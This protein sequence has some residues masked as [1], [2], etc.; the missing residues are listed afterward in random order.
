MRPNEI[1]ELIGFAAVADHKS[2]RRAA[3]KLNLTPS[4]LSHSLRSL[5]ERLGVRLLNRTTRSVGLTDAG[6]ALLEQVRPALRQLDA[7]VEG[8]NA[9]S[10]APRGTVR[11]NVPHL[12][13][14]MVFGR[15]LGDFARA[16]PGIVLDIATDDRFVDIVAQ[17][18]DAGIRLGE[19]VDQDMVAVRVTA[20]LRNI[21]VG[22]PGYF[23]AHP[24]PLTVPDDLSGHACIGYRASGSRRL[25]K[26]EFERAGQ[27][28]AIAPKGPLILDSHDLLIE[29]ALAGAGLAYV[30]EASVQDALADGRLVR[31]LDDWCQPFDG[32]FLY[33]PSHRQLSAAMRAVID[34]FRSELNRTPPEAELVP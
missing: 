28:V 20:P 2:F 32:F 9:F 22:A 27:A 29:A 4:T 8:V 11:L 12:A 14:A 5:E 18:F 10:P 16:Y 24:A 15:R 3:E 34:F 17:G 21:V 23:A 25:Y 30:I 26:W 33:Y 13:A 31:V 7:A 19:S 6:L 1:A